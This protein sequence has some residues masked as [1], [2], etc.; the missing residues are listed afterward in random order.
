MRRMILV[1]GVLPMI[2]FGLSACSDDDDGDGGVGVTLSDFKIDLATTSAPAGSVTFK[3]HN[4]IVAGEVQKSA[5]R[6]VEVKPW[7]ITL[8]GDDFGL[9]Q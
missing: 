9:R 5:Q 8:Q 4:A 3:V 2:T 6:Q 7:K 1:L